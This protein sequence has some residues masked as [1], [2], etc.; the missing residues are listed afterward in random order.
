M[1]AWA[2]GA[3]F[4]EADLKAIS[5]GVIRHGRALPQAQGG[6]PQPI[7]CM[8]RDDGK[9]IAG[10]TGR[11]EFQRLYINYL[12][13][14]EQCRGDGLGTAC[15]HRIEALAFERGCVDALIE[16]LNDDVA[17]W[18][19]RCGYQLIALLPKYCG[20]LTSRHT[21]LKQLD[22]TCVSER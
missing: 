9:L 2:T 15:L 18:Y 12:W 5:D 1:R 8:A 20:E 19:S 6:Q 14:D 11:T 17:Q 21:L 16:T 10:V 3:D 7:A 13:V 22:G 4:N